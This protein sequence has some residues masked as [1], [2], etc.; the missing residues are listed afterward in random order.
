MH[1][2][3]VFVLPRRLM[4]TMLLA[5]AVLIALSV[6]YTYPLGIYTLRLVKQ[7]ILYDIMLDPGHGGIDPGAIGA[8]E[9]Y[10]KHYV[11]DIVLQMAEILRSHGL[12]VGLTR[13]TDRDVS[14]LVSEGTRHRRDLL[15]RFKLMDQAQMGMSVHT[16]STKNKEESGAIVFYMNDQYVDEIYAQIVLEE[17][18]KVQ[19]LNEPRPIPRSTLLLLKAKPPVIL[20]ELG[21]MSNP[22]DLAKLGDP[23]FRGN[24]AQALCS[25]ILRF[26][27]WRYGEQSESGS[28]I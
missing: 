5:V 23:A 17:L 21:F 24:V 14:H 8:G 9:I 12:K 22:R 18:E 25:G 6:Y 16:N 27:D 1:L 15:G 26:I 20:V 2:W 3:H 28:P 19:V 7:D 4:G 10:E 13:E 11:L